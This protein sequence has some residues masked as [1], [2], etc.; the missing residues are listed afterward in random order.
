[1]TH[2]ASS[3][4]LEV[5]KTKKTYTVSYA[6]NMGNDL[7]DVAKCFNCIYGKQAFDKFLAV[8]KTEGS[9]DYIWWSTINAN[10]FEKMFGVL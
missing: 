10:K 4:F 3:G 7:E 6:G 9:P 5:I 2:V 1:M 8:A